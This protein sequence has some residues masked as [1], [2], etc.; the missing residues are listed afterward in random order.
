MQLIAM[1]GDVWETDSWETVARDQALFGEEPERSSGDF[2]EAE[3]GQILAMLDR[4]SFAE[5]FKRRV[6]VVR[7]QECVHVFDDGG[8]RIN[9]PDSFVCD[10]LQVCVP[11]EEDGWR[12]VDGTCRGAGGWDSPLWESSK[13][14]L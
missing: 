9:E 7:G 10:G 2:W 5:M 14:S 6:F 11:L 13:R 12:P 4:N 1:T 8:S 3:E